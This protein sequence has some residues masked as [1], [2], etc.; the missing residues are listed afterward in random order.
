MRIAIVSPYDLEVAGGVQSHVSA[1]AAALR[2]GGDEVVEIGPGRDREGRIGLGRSVRVPANGSRAPIALA[3]SVVPRV[4]A[5]LRRVR[6]DVIHVHEPLVPLVGPTASL[7]ASV[8]VVLTFHAYAERGSLVGLARAARPLG[9]RVVR[10]AAALTAVSAVAARFHARALG[11]D[12]RRFEVIPN[13]VDVARFARGSAGTAAPQRAEDA[14]T[15]LFVGRFEER[16]GVD[17]AVRAFMQLAAERPTLRLHLVGDGPE[18][19]A[20]ETLIA[21]MPEAIAARIRRSGR[22]SNAELPAALGAADVLLVPSRGG[23]SF[24]IILLEAMAAGTALV[25]SDLDGYRAVARPGR[26]ALLV[27]PGDAPA[28][29]AAA[30]RLLDDSVLRAALVAAGRARVARFDWSEV[31]ART[32]DVYARIVGDEGS[33]SV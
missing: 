4:R 13:G 5:A 21:G 22:L 7:S 3:P 19:R 29:A 17:V 2:S 24:G 32:R 1:L 18:A 12:V 10:A 33:R 15:V 8:P 14:S 26:E 11:V 20:V 28:L 30:G 27:P 9:R 31:A 6:P 23:E 16:K 25:A